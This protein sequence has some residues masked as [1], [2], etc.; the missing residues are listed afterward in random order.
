MSYR[1][2]LRKDLGDDEGE[3][4]KLYRCTAGKLTIGRGHNIEDRGISPAVMELMYE[5][6]VQVAERDALALF[7]GLFSYS[8]RRQ[9]ALV[10]MAFQLGYQRLKDFKKMRAAV[11]V[12]DWGAAVYE[13]ND[14]AWAK[15]T[16]KSR[17]DRV[18]TDLAQG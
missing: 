10:N 15:Q 8:E 2:K 4:L 6:D 7:P 3:R 17:V 12:G 18:L 14:S 9:A 1:D 5:E 16:Q 13:A 11:N